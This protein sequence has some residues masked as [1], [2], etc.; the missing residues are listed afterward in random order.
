MPHLELNLARKVKGKRRG[1]IQF[2]S[3]EK[4]T[5]EYGPAAE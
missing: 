3:S 1:F 2:M 5:R 4:R